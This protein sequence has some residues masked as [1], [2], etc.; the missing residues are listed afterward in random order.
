MPRKKAT[1]K[2]VKARTTTSVSAKAKALVAKSRTECKS[3]K[4]WFDLLPM[5][6]QHYVEAVVAA[7]ID[8]PNSHP[9]TVARL[10]I[11]ELGITVSQH[12]VAKKI[13]ELIRNG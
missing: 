5:K 4:S 6:D 1:R 3:K 11:E 9:N 10:L 2:P 13:K 8:E 12:N 7:M